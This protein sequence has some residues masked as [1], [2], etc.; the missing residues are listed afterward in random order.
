MRYLLMI[1]LLAACGSSSKPEAKAPKDEAPSEVAKTTT[2]TKKVKKK[3]KKRRP[4]KEAAEPAPFEPAPLASLPD[5]GAIKLVAAKR[6]VSSLKKL[7]PKKKKRS[8]GVAC[9]CAPVGEATTEESWEDKSAT[10]EAKPE[11]LEAPLLNLQLLAVQTT[12]RVKKGSEEPPPMDVVF[13]LAMQTR[14]GWF[15]A[16]LGRT[17][18]EPAQGYGATFSLASQAYVDLP[19]NGVKSVMAT[20]EEKKFTSGEEGARASTASGWLLLCNAANPKKVSCSAPIS[21]GAAQ[22]KG[23]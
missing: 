17:A 15:N 2:E 21:L 23:G 20:L 16:E 18:M 13:G 9:L 4:M 10:C 1:L 5:R 22:A 7:C 19:G 3:K 11:G 12:G 6:P 8:G 14:K